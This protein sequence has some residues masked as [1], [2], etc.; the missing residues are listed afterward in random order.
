MSI[1][2]KCINRSQHNF[3]HRQ[4]VENVFI[5]T[6]CV[7]FRR[8][9]T[10]R[11]GKGSAERMRPALRTN[12]KVARS[13]GFPFRFPRRIWRE[14]SGATAQLIFTRLLTSVIFE[15]KHMLKDISYFQV[16]LEQRV[17]SAG[18]HRIFGRSFT[19][20]CLYGYCKCGWRAP[21]RVPFRA[22]LEGI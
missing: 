4:L 1:G 9:F 16:S 15:L 19:R 2:N 8:P 22:G 14:G 7:C 21:K 3:N 18:H 5:P 6:I 12:W 10:S 17:C 13:L 20:G 11:A